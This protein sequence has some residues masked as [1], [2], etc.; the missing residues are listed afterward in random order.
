MNDTVILASYNST[1]EAYIVKGMLE[2]NGIPAMV[3]NENN[4]YVPVFN[5]INVLVFEKDLARARQLME[6]HGD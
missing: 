2:C 5:G 3:A 1:E 6:E 4:L